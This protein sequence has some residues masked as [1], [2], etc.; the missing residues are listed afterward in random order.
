MVSDDAAYSGARLPISNLFTRALKTPRFY[1]SGN[2][3]SGKEFHSLAVCTRKLEAKH[4]VRSSSATIAVCRGMLLL[5]MP[6][7]WLGTSRVPRHTVTRRLSLYALWKYTK[8]Q[9]PADAGPLCNMEENGWVMGIN[10][11]M[12]SLALG[13]ARGSVRLLLTK[14]HPVPI[15]AFRVGAPVNPL[16]TR[17]TAS[18]DSHRTDRIIS[19]AYMRCVLMTS[20]V[21]RAM[22]ACGPLGYFFTRDVLC[23]V[24]VDRDKLKDLLNERTQPH[25]FYPRRGRQRCSLRHVMPLYNVHPLFNICVI[26][27]IN[28]LPDPGI[29]PL[30]RQSH[31]RPLDQRGSQDLLN[32]VRPER[33]APHARVWF[34]SGGELPLIAVL[35]PAL[36]VA[37]DRPAIPDA[38][39]DF[40]LCRGCVYKHTSSHTHDTQTRNNNLWI[41]QRV[42]PCGNR[43]RYPL[44]GSQL[45]SHRPNR[46]VDGTLR[47]TTEKSSK[48]RKK[49]S[50]TSSGPGVKPETTCPAV[51]LATTRP[52]MQ[53]E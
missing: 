13:K 35:R 9:S 27:S 36:T 43:T 46:A 25:A 44:R 41:T 14:N 51:A 39:N 1:P 38:R 49:P 33:D 18:P 15:P 23:Y 16:E 22:R 17:T 11:P 21:M 37:G 28:T 10:H 42:A 12:T 6:L 26:S 20:Y 8:G 30:V 45:P 34:W 48:N 32:D 5:N 50:N 19:N 3:D 31:L 52:T 2:T 4:F 7:A 47:A 40:L 24:A 29:E 53:S